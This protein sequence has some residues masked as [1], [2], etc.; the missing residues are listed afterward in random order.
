MPRAY[1][2]N[3]VLFSTDILTPE[4]IHKNICINDNKDIKLIS[5][6]R[7]FYKNNNKDLKKGEKDKTVEF[8][9]STNKL[10]LSNPP[11]QKA[12][13]TLVLKKG[14]FEADYDNKEEE[15]S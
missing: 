11:K 1:K 3:E 2:L 7:V 10:K 14:G 9:E 15:Q 13:D 6:W 12:L 5:T 4:E 8:N